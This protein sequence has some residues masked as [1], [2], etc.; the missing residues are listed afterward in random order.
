VETNKTTTQ[1]PVK[2]VVPTTQPT[3][4]VT[5]QPVKPPP[6]RNT[7]KTTGTK[8]SKPILLQ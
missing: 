8:P 5:T 3:R 6:T 7:P 4:V 2:T 1:P